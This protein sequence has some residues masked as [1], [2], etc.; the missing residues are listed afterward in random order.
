MINTVYVKVLNT[1]DVDFFK[2]K[3]SSILKPE[4]ILDA[5]RYLQEKDKRLH[6]LSA[7][8]KRKYL[9]EWTT[10]DGKP[11]KDGVFF[12]LSHSEELVVIAFGS[13]E[14]GV[15]VEKIRAVDEDLKNYV[16]STKEKE[17]CKTDL[18]FFLI[19]TAKESLVKAK[20]VGFDRRPDEIPALPLKG[21]KSYDDVEYYSDYTTID[22]YVISLTQKGGRFQ[23]NLS[24]ETI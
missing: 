24:K 2:V 11:Y 14:L 18:D 8:L 13:D 22:N 10:K 1:N 6:L 16:C 21:K 7:Y 3:S 17:T 4:D 19:W 5:E 9:S 20:G 12:N 15:D 23:I